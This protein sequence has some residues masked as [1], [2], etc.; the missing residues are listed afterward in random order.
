MIVSPTL[1]NLESLLDLSA[2]L[3]ESRDEEYILSSVLLSLMGKLRL[4]RAC[5]LRPS[6]ERD[7]YEVA[8]SKGKIS[9]E[10]IVL[11]EIREFV[12]LEPITHA[13]LWNHGFRFC[14]PACYQDRVLALLCLGERLAEPEL[15]DEEA[16]YA[17]LVAMITANALQHLKTLDSLIQAKNSVEHRN[18]LL[19]SIFEM[20]RDFSTLLT[21]E[22]ILRLLSYRLMGQMMVS[23]FAL[24]L[25][26]NGDY[27]VIINR[28]GAIPDAEILCR[29]AHIEETLPV[30]TITGEEQA[31]FRNSNIE[32]YSTMMV[33]GECK[34]ILLIGRKLHGG[35]FSPDDL[36]FI[37]ALGNTA[38]A[39]LENARLFQEELMK[40]RLE[41]ELSLAKDIQSGLL[42]RSLP[43]SEKFQIAA[44]T[45]QTSHV[46]GD[47]YDVIPLSGEQILFAVADVSGKG[48]PAALLMSN[49]QASLRTLAPLS[50]PIREIVTRINS[51]I[52]H[53]TTSDKFVTLFCG[54]LDTVN[55]RFTYINAGHNPPLLLS[56]DGSFRELSEGGLILGIM[57]G[58]IP[59]A[60]GSESILGSE[61]LLMF[62]DGVSEAMNPAREEF[63]EERI[64]QVLAQ[65]RDKDA[66]EIL[67]ELLAALRE[68]TLGAAQSDDIT[69]LV[70]K[71]V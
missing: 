56:Q 35:R 36:Q 21:R 33:N 70:V 48:M 3:N 24:L 51:I 12:P 8:A 42:P 29:F 31:I 62:S 53:N 22:Q 44:T 71:G 66:D 1:V 4:T 15:S 63:T 40:K 67:A 52:Y 34:G 5:A 68:H 57:D 60:V 55:N 69:M 41:S 54:I 50:I 6:D 11:P 59:Y 47:Y 19:T 28:L 45:I 46:G 65:A 49:V 10:S 43:Q 20:S 30:E 7:G 61:V 18:Q 58:D 32:I 37:E 2:R 39:A 25:H 14:V 9:F 27:E 26:Q 64:K 17:S 13:E 16:Q 38:I 23:K